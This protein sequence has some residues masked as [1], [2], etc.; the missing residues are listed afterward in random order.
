M[1]EGHKFSVVR[2][3]RQRLLNRSKNAIFIPAHVHLALPVWMIP[4]EFRIKIFC[5]IKLESLGYRVVLF[6]RS[7]F[8]HFDIIPACDRQTDRQTDGYAM[9]ANTAL[10]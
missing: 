1:A 2:R 7:F 5:V 4:S 10:A 8:S 6:L 9:T 3:L